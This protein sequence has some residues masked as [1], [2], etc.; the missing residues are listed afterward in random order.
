MAIAMGASNDDDY[1]TKAVNFQDP[2]LSSTNLGES[3]ELHTVLDFW[4]D[5]YL[6][7]P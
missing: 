1:V 5:A 6:W 2:T 7:M 4:V 3:F